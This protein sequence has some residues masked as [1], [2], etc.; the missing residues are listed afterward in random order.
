MSRRR[1]SGEM[2][3]PIVQTL[4]RVAPILLASD[5]G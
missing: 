5:I 4:G 3:L 1:C 2:T